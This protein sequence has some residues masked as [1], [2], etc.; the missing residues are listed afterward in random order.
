MSSV[1][2]GPVEKTIYPATAA[3]DRWDRVRRGIL[4][5]L[6]ALLAIA[7]TGYHP[8]A[9]DAGIYVAGIK[10]AAHPGLY[11]GS[12]FFIAPYLRV[13]LFP[14]LGAWVVQ[15][16]HV[17]LETFL[18]LMQIL[19]TWLLL[20][21]CWSL[22]KHCFG[23]PEERWAAVLL[24]A[25]CLSVPV[26]GTSLFLMDPYL[27]SRSFSTPLS[28]LAL[29]ACLERKFLRGFLLLLLIGLF[30]PLMVIYAA[31]FV[32]LLSAVEAGSLPGIAALTTAGFATAAAITFSQR[33]LVE[34]V[35]YQN[36][37]GSRY[38]FFLAHWHWYEQLGVVAPVVIL[39]LYGRKCRPG[40]FPKGVALA[41]S[42]A[43]LGFISIAVA[44]IFARSSSHSH[45]VAALQPLR[46]FLLVYFCMFVLLG[47][48]IG[49]A[50]LRRSAWR[51]IVL[52]AGAGAG[53][54]F[55]QHQAYPA[56]S[57]IEFP[58]AVSQNGWMRAFL[59]I[60]GNT[61]PNARFALD[62]DY[63]HAPGE[64]SQGFRAIAER[65]SLADRS[66]DGGA[67]AVFRELADR[68][69]IEQTATTGLNEIDDAERLRRL[70]PFHVDWI[71]LSASSTT[72]LHCPFTDDA[73]KVCRLRESE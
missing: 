9:E 14:E 13:S 25:V 30:H 67:A 18:F 56:S 64:D 34:S 26:A 38:Y 28:L 20:F 48:L 1:A 53:L 10:S 52:F 71:V 63:I 31:F 36:A 4:L 42:C 17:P 21:A 69:W 58:R 40:A 45:L 11:G 55:A 54:A 41:R 39:G 32:L 66:K 46:P 43:L 62:S 73:V 61:P 47:G 60:R 12:S 15:S 33:N 19:T 3:E 44:L 2:N 16:L 37:V 50:L 7:I 22:A 70:D 72:R 5:L 59:W 35:A 65:D 49:R 57:Q 27:T 29:A 51:W 23:R 6:L 24:S 8:Y 68:W